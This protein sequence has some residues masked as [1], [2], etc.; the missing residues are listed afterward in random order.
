MRADKAILHDF[1]LLY[2]AVSV[3]AYFAAWIFVCLG[4]S[5]A[6]AFFYNF[7]AWLFSCGFAAVLLSTGGE[8]LSYYS[9]FT[10]VWLGPPFVMAVESVRVIA[11]VALRKKGIFSDL[12]RE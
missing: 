9:A 11:Y 2:F 7:I 12:D 6:F 3:L 10:V 4:G 1:C 5:D 8:V